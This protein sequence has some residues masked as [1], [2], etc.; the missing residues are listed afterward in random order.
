MLKYILNFLF[1]VC[2]E[3]KKRIFYPHL[4]TTQVIE[5]KNN[6]IIDKYLIHMRCDK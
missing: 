6:K 4:F 1:P 2:G 3:C 5:K